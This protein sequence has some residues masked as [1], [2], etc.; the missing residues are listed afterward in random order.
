MSQNKKIFESE[1]R[2]GEATVCKMETEVS[3]SHE[4]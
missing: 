3:N 1:A 2:M 4:V